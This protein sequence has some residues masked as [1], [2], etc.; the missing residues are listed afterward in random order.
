[1]TLKKYFDEKLDFRVR[2][3]NV[4]AVG[5]MAV[6]AFMS[7]KAVF[8]P[9]EKWD[10]LINGAGAVLAWGLLWYSYKS[11]RYRFCYVISISVFFL[12]LFPIMFFLNDGYHG[13]MPI[14]FVF[15]VLFTVFM[16][17]GKEALIVVGTEVL[18]YA[19]LFF[20]AWRYPEYTVPFET[21]WLRAQDIAFAFVCASGVL[22]AAMFLHFRMYKDQQRRLKEAS[23][24]KTAF[25]ASTSHE[26][27]TPLNII[28]GMNEMIRGAVTAG[29]VAE[30]S[31]EIQAAGD[32]LR[33]LID[34]LLDI[35][36]IEAGKQK[37]VVA[38]Y[39]VSEMI[40]ELAV[41]GEQETRKRGLDFE[42]HA[43]PDMPSKLCG[44]FSRIRQVVINFL[45]NAAKYTERGTVTLTADIDRT[46]T[47]EQG[48][49][50]L[51]LSVSDTGIGI[52]P[53]DIGS[54]FEKFS[55]G[56]AA[57]SPEEPRRQIAGVGLGL[58]IAKE[59]TDLMGGEIQMESAWGEG[60]K[61][62]LLVPQRSLDTA[63]LGDWRLFSEFSETSFDGESRFTA[64]LGG[65]LAV[66]DNPGNL[67]V[68]RE[69]L[70]RTRLRINTASSGREC[71]EAVKKAIGA[72]EPCHVI[73]M[74]YMMPEMDGVETLK[75]LR[76]E[77]PAFDTPVVAFTADAITGEREKLLDAGFAAYLT[78]P[79]ARSDLEKTIF[80][81]LPSDV[82]VSKKHDP[83][84]TAEAEITGSTRKEWEHRLSSEYGL[85]LSEGLKYA[86]GDLALFRTQAGIFV[87]NFASARAVIESKRDKEDWAGMA[88]LVH[89]LK[90]GAGYTGAT[91]LRDIAKETE[92]ACRAGDTEYANLA[93]PLLFLEWERAYRGLGVFLRYTDKSAYEAD[94]AELN[95]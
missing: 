26:I 34:E 81:L 19:S 70:R 9:G 65:I 29:P 4:L 38:E 50:T 73:L 60:S 22:G 40:H 25:L 90:G 36:R 7:L 8:V 69:F 11:G 28:L 32:S 77:I 88:R 6:C 5:G 24:A 95:V 85:S 42:V 93:L 45:V 71:V 76:E 86:S 92:R 12:A 10:L 87:E 41:A 13:G 94:G 82:V 83:D 78:K 17:D 61:F 64:P 47:I 54:L 27:R 33:E 51:R 58:A 72:G 52:R 2:L 37:T 31:G 21:E 16:L 18:L 49:V 3:Y 53:E 55:Q 35:S 20:A 43:D 59:L 30:W 66:D 79:V 14:F 84:Q 75:K 15:A 57:N 48:N 62:S 67:R 23:E 46:K 80:A 44:D 89:A 74:D 91:R 68:V 39:H 1:M 63:P 56:D